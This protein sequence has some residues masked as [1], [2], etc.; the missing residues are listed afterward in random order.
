MCSGGG[1]MNL[2][3]DELKWFRYRCNDCGKVYK[4][5]SE[6]SSICPDCKSENVTKV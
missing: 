1:P 2:M 5:T 6:R 4:S 3:I